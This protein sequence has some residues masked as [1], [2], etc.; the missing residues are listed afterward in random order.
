MEEEL[1]RMR[2]QLTEKDRNPIPEGRDSTDI[3][4]FFL[5]K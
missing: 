5:L 2:L 3:L 1:R 4:H